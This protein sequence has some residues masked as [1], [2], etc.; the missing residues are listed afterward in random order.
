MQRSAYCGELF[1]VQF[2]FSLQFYSNFPSIQEVRQSSML[3]RRTNQPGCESWHRLRQRVLVRYN[4][5]Q[6]EP[7]SHCRIKSS[8]LPVLKA[9]LLCAPSLAFSTC[10]AWS[11]LT[12]GVIFNM[13]TQT[14]EN[15]PAS[16]WSQH[17]DKGSISSSVRRKKLHLQNVRELCWEILPLIWKGN[18]ST[19]LHITAW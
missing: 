1:L 12:A 13:L 19:S 8:F 3:G 18:P 9:V 10:P 11:S 2:S 4:K 7:F 14:N 6:L 17:I 5:S 15:T 16:A